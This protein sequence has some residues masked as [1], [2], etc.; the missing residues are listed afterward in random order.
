MFFSWSSSWLLCQDHCFFLFILVK[1]LFFFFLDYLN[2]T[3]IRSK[4]CYL[5][6]FLKIFIPTSSG[7]GTGQGCGTLSPLSRFLYAT[8]TIWGSFSGAAVLHPI[9]AYLNFDRC[10]RLRIR[11]ANRGRQPPIIGNHTSVPS[12]MSKMIILSVTS[13]WTLMTVCWLISWPVC[14][15]ISYNRA[16]VSH[17]PMLL[18]EH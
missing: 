14:V 3:F 12:I 8:I 7:Y 6:L 4:V 10:I 1:I 18:S 13:Q 17:T 5:T 2:L 9:K 16:V 15:I 11:H